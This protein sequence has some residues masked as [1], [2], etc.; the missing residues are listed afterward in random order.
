MKQGMVPV[1]RTAAVKA[2]KAYIQTCVIVLGKPALEAA[3]ATST[4]PRCNNIRQS[5]NIVYN[6]PDRQLEKELV[7]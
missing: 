6:L 4:Y 7:G 1:T 3:T 5:Q 2:V